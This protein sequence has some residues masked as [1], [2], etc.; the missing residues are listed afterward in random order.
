MTTEENEILSLTAEYFLLMTDEVHK[1]FKKKHLLEELPKAFQLYGYGDYDEIK[2]SLKKDFEEIGTE[3][4]NGKY[5][6]DKVRQ[7]HKGRP[8]VKLSKYYK[9]IILH[10][11]EYENFKEFMNNNPLGKEEM[12]EQNA[13]L[14]NEVSSRIFYY[15]SY[16][17]GEDNTILKGQTVISENFKKI[18]HTY[19]YPQDDGTYKTHYSFGAIVRREDTLHINSK[20]LLDGKLVEGG[21]EIYYIGHNEPSN[22]KFLIGT[23][24]TFDIY[25]QTVAGKSIFEKCDSKEEME[26]KSKDKIIPAYI[27]QEIRKSRIINPSIVPKD[28][29][30][31]SNES[32]YASIYGL[33]P[34][35]YVLQFELNDASKETLEFSVAQNDFRIKPNTLNVHFENE[36]FN[37]INKGSIVHFNFK[38]IGIIGIDTVDVYFKTYFL[39][40]KNEIV[41]GVFSGVDYENRLVNGNVFI[42]YRKE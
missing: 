9:T 28:V 29:M 4:I 22:T 17:Y 6:Y 18:K 38:L 32:P 26:A 36:Q 24:C 31:L 42:E 35:I 30:E 25:T 7:T 14:H 41:K 39:K 13:L 10:Y 19:V 27:A 33:I 23:Y 15:I 3:F 2:P 21:S 37:L 8:V 16:Y 40:E 1:Q 20:T 34:G 12:E 5:L 11:L